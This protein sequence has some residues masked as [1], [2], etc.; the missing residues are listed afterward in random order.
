M[1]MRR[2]AGH[3][4]LAQIGQIVREA[5]HLVPAH[6]GV[7]EQ[8]TGPALHDD[9]VGLHELALVDEHT[10]RDRSQHGTPSVFAKSMRPARAGSV[11]PGRPDQP[12][13]LIVG[14]D[15]ANHVRPPTWRGHPGRP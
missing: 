5:A 1:R 12:P 11:M 2:E 3:D 15:S 8:H 10:V 7:D 9:G 13:K 14:W 4:G 6:P